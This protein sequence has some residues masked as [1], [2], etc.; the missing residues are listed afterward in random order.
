MPAR[1]GMYE[2][3]PARKPSREVRRELCHSFAPGSNNGKNL[4]GASE[5]RPLR[6]FTAAIVR[7]HKYHTSPPLFARAVRQKFLA[8]LPL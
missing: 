5:N 3:Y 2:F 7:M 6:I 4:T 8:A 1:C